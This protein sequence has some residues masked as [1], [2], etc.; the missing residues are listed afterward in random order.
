MQSGPV[1]YQPA[2]RKK[3]TEAFPDG[4]RTFS[5]M[6]HGAHLVAD[7]M[8]KP[9]PIKKEENS[10]IEKIQQNRKGFSIGKKEGKSRK[11]VAPRAEACRI[12]HPGMEFAGY[13]WRK[14][15]EWKR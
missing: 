11:Y 2:G 13:G 10:G 5:G 12:E 9:Y 15:Q 1:P 6:D 14:K 8:K 4:K 3:Q 7:G